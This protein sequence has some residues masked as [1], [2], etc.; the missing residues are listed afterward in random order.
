M[1]H[2]SVRRPSDRELGL[3]NPT[4][5]ACDGLLA[6]LRTPNQNVLGSSLA[7]VSFS[8]THPLPKVLV[9]RQ[10]AVSPAHHDKNV[11]REVKPKYKQTNKQT[12]KY[13]WRR[14]V[15]LRKIFWLIQ[16]QRKLR[17]CPDNILTIT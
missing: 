2:L 4:G 12:N 7:G 9:S 6:W 13:H 5:E 15:F 8:K 16:V 10:K 11:D 1:A 14:E 17:L 3:S